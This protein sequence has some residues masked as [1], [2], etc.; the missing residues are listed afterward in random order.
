MP[1]KSANAASIDNAPKAQGDAG[2]HTQGSTDEAGICYGSLRG[3][4]GGKKLN[5]ALKNNLSPIDDKYILF[6]TIPVLNI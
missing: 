5:G 6:N 3:G 4:G 2:L 1:V